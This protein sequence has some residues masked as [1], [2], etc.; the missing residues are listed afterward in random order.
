MG[1]L[2]GSLGL[3]FVSEEAEPFMIPGSLL[4]RHQL[5][6]VLLPPWSDGTLAQRPSCKIPRKLFCTTDQ[7]NSYRC[8]GRLCGSCTT[9]NITVC[10]H[11]NLIMSGPVL[12]VTRCMI[13]PLW[14]VFSIVQTIYLIANILLLVW[15]IPKGL[16]C[17]FSPMH[18][19]D[20]MH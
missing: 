7:H 9:S 16:H 6:I 17:K 8:S 1:V 3:H 10:S 12:T 11:N 4:I 19:D 13:Y 18:L 20:C 15:F 2:H 5:P 14:S